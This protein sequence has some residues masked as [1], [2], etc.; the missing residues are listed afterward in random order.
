MRPAY[1]PPQYKFC[2]RPDAAAVTE[3]SPMDR[4]V[5]Q[6]AR[7]PSLMLGGMVVLGVLE[8]VALQRSQRQIRRQQHQQALRAAA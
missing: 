1:A 2:A 3:D 4:I 5:S 8:F 7:R 6:L